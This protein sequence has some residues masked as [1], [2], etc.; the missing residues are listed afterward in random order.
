[1]GQNSIHSMTTVL[2]LTEVARAICEHEQ[3]FKHYVLTWIPP[4]ASLS[5]PTLPTSASTNANTYM[6]FH[7]FILEVKLEVK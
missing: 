2:Q 7:I 4:F 1:M 3:F 5:T 6:S